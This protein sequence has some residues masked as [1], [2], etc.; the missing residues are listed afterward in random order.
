MRKKNPIKGVQK[1]LHIR[2]KFDPNCQ[3]QKTHASEIRS[4]TKGGK[5]PQNHYLKKAYNLK[6][7]KN[8]DQMS[9]SQLFKN[10]NQKQS[11]NR[12]PDTNPD[13]YTYIDETERGIKPSIW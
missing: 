11:S 9:Q 10:Q 2:P 8:Y 7:E 12:S 13:L 4:K 1:H 3:H 6:N 5:T